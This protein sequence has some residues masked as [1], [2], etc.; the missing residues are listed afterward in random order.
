TGIGPCHRSGPSVNLTDT[1]HAPMLLLLGLLMD[2]LTVLVVCLTLFG[3]PTIVSA[4]GKQPMTVENLFAFKRVA[5]PPVSP[6]GKLACYV[7]ASV[8]LAANKT[9]SAIWLASTEKGEPRQLTNVPGK[10]DSHPRW[11]PDGKKILFQSNRSGESQLWVIDL[12]GGEAKQLT[13]I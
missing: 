11:S 1:V 8:D 5:D 12:S 4:D 10:K 7:V 6:D 9:S 3:A 2:R 13:T